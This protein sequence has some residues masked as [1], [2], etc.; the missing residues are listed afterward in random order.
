M[1]NTTAFANILQPPVADLGLS[2]IREQ[3]KNRFLNSDIPS[4]KQEDWRYIN[5]K[6]LFDLKYA[7][8]QQASK[9]ADKEFRYRIIFN[10][11]NV[12]SFDLPNGL[13]LMTLSEAM[14]AKLIR[15]QD[16]MGKNQNLFTDLNV[17]SLTKGYYLEIEGQIK[18][19]ILIRY[20]YPEDGNYG[21]SFIY[22]LAKQNSLAHFI[23]DS[24]V[25]DHF[26]NHQFRFSLERDSYLDWTQVHQ[27]Q[28][29]NKYQNVEAV[30][31]EN[32]SLNYTQVNLGGG[33]VR[34]D[35]SVDLLAPAANA[36]LQ[37]LYLLRESQVVDNHTVVNHLAPNASCRQ[38]YKGILDNQSKA[39]FDG[40]IYVA[41]GADGTIASQ[42]NKNILLSNA[43]EV[44]A[45]PQLEIYADDVKCN[46][47]ATLGKFSDEE[48]FYFMSRGITKNQAI[49]MLSMGFVRDIAMQIG[50]EEV[51][52]HILPMI[53]NTLK[54]YAF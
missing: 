34:Q 39:I 27:T 46:H 28:K 15:E 24:S 47:G 40:K 50:N 3:A 52:K 17:A 26:T 19:P 14:N 54:E 4:R 7:F 51:Q 53:N 25:Q 45:K 9:Y 20:L 16:L 11:S 1:I 32:A 43:A 30:V 29:A 37:G 22:V 42:M 13:K 49:Q 44:D 23:D 21:S 35:L 5:V 2:S 8:G 18:E 36:N 6:P 33:I 12:E 41:P 10:N 48:I 31:K 38:N